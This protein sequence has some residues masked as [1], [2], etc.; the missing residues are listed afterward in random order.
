MT[1]LKS[2]ASK[3]AWLWQEIS[4]T[5][6]AVFEFPV[7][8]TLLEGPLRGGGDDDIASLAYVGRGLNLPHIKKK[9]FNSVE[10]RASTKANLLNFRKQIATV[11]AEADVTFIDVG[12]P[13][14][15]RINRGGDYLELPDWV[16][17]VT[18]LAETWDATVQNFRRT[19]R[20]NIRR[21]IRKNNY[22]LEATKDAADIS[23]FMRS[24]TAHLSVRAMPVRCS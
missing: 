7:Q 1:V 6:V 5:A 24:T 21:L 18:P 4:E 10:E 20:K 2:V 14:H 9:F 8:I 12:W 17:M 23:S 15:G 19:M 13:Y 11:E 3:A 16:C 22:R